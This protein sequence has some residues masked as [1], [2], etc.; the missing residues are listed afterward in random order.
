MHEPINFVK[1]L[2]LYMKDC[3]CLVPTYTQLNIHDFVNLC[4][5]SNIMF[6]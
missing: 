1:A 6:I 4:N 5:L 3:I 2:F